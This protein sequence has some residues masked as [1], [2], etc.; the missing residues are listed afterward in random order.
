MPLQDFKNM[1][2]LSSINGRIIAIA[3]LA[4]LELEIFVNESQAYFT[5]EMF[6]VYFI[7]YEID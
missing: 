3:D 6:A 2:K 5:L 1:L 4:W 7:T